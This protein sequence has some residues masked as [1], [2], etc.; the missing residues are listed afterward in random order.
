MVDKLE[1]VS[2]K[3]R[4]RAEAVR[5]M[6]VFSEC[7]FTDTRL[8]I[9][10][11]KLRKK[12]DAFDEETKLPVLIIDNTYRIIG[13]YE[14]SKW[15]AEKNDLYGGLPGERKDIEEV[16]ATL[17]ELHKGLAPTLRATLTRNYDERRAVWNEFK[18]KT[19][20]PCLE[21]Y[22]KELADRMFLVGTNISWADIALIEVLTRLQSCYDS[23]YLA[24][25]PVLKEYCHRFETLPIMRPY[26]QTRPETHF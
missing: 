25:F 15:V 13:V 19:L 1:L 3:G 16:I 8:T 7:P 14:I 12:R 26:I 2:L 20:I 21:K 22:E 11:W 18:E 5:L 17:D 10:E 24:H 6:L 4:G 9:A 23:F